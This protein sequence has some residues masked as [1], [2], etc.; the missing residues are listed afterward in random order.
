MTALFATTYDRFQ[1]LGF[2]EEV[3]AVF[4]DIQKAFDTIAHHVLLQKL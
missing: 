3:C 4:F 1:M 2:G